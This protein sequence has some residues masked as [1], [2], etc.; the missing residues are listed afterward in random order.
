MRMWKAISDWFRPPLVMREAIRE[1]SIAKTHHVLMDDATCYVANVGSE[2]PNVVLS[3]RTPAHYG[4]S[5]G[6][7]LI[8]HTKGGLTARYQILKLTRMPGSLYF[9]ECRFSPRIPLKPGEV[10]FL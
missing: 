8:L 1:Y 4:W 6:D 2:V 5:D 10:S 3:G 9:A 7:Y